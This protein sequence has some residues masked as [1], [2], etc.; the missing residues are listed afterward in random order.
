MMK[1]EK[2]RRAARRKRHQHHRKIHEFKTAD[3]MDQTYI[4]TQLTTS[5]KRK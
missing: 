4:Y 1:N 2:E 5:K 3:R